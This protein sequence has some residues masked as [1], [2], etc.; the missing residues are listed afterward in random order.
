MV[1]V[2]C[3]LVTVDSAAKSVDSVVTELRLVGST[4]ESVGSAIVELGMTISVV[5]LAGFVAGG[6]VVG[7]VVVGGVVVG[8]VVAVGLSATL[9]TDSN[10]VDGRAEDAPICGP[11]GN[12]SAAVN[13]VALKLIGGSTRLSVGSGVSAILIKAAALAVSS[14]P[15]LL[16]TVV[17]P[18]TIQILKSDSTTNPPSM[19]TE[20]P[21]A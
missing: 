9:A 12:G 11:S 19:S 7:G 3:G 18:E 6:V 20:A 4:V 21:I 16:V 1:F 5:E 10:V 17:E 14:T 15:P 2:V 8:C 13:R